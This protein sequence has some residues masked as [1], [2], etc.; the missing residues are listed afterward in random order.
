MPTVL[1]RLGFPNNTK[2]N[3]N[4]GEH[5]SIRYIDDNG[6]QIIRQ[7]T[8][9]TTQFH[10]NYLDLGIKLYPNGAMS[11]YLRYLP[12]GSKIQIKGPSGRLQYKYNSIFTIR[13]FDK[14][15]KSFKL[16][17]YNIKNLVLI[18]GGSGISPILQVL[19]ATY[20]ENNI[21]MN[22]NLFYGASSEYDLAFKKDIDSIQKNRTKNVNVYYAVISKP[23][24]PNHN[25]IVGYITK[26]IL[27]E[28]L[29][30]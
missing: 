2:L 9:V 17:T 28:K 18:A 16:H 7:Y 1:Y 8:P 25:Y 15:S 23:K 10:N 6:K 29:S 20:E 19:K 4:V 13:K 12:V 30:L 22:I 11:Q 24:Y 3:I 27:Q 5:I 26:D 14:Q 21:S